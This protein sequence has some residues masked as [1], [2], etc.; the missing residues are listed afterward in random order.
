MDNLCHQNENL[1][2]AL[3]ARR[4][5]IFFAVMK[6]RSFKPTPLRKEKFQNLNLSKIKELLNVECTLKSPLAISLL[7]DGSF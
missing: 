3:F 1:H 5:G 7:Q 2:S 6:G 4:V